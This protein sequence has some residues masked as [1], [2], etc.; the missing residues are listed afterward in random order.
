[1]SALN[2]ITDAKFQTYNKT[3]NQLISAV[4]RMQNHTQKYTPTIT[5]T[6]IISKCGSPQVH[7][8]EFTKYISFHANSILFIMNAQICFYYDSIN[9]LF[10]NYKHKSI[11][12]HDTIL[13]QSVHKQITPIHILFQNRTYNNLIL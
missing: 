6:N 7:T 11:P 5:T 13:R 2:I 12:T 8:L 1:V 4:P 3:T 10:Q 9:S